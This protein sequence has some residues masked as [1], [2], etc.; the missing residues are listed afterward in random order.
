MVGTFLGFYSQP[1]MKKQ[2][3]AAAILS[4]VLPGAAFAQQATKGP[5]TARARAVHLNSDNGDSTGLGLS[6]NNKW[7]PE[8]D[9]SYFFQPEPGA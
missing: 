1:S 3:V 4:T 2:L 6:M 9:I 7:M 5:W 8:A